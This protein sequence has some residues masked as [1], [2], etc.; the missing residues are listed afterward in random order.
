M[1]TFDTLTAA[2]NLQAA[3][4]D[5]KHADAIVDAMRSP[6]SEHVATKSDLRELEQRLTE[7]EQR[8]TI[9]LGALIFAGPGLL[10]AALKLTT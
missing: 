3:G 4:L 10:F 8:L 9:R 2:R 5:P 6:V 7:L 1:T